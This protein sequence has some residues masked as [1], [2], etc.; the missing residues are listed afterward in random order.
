MGKMAL[1]GTL[2]YHLPIS[3]SVV[4]MFVVFFSHVCSFIRSSFIHKVWNMLRVF[5]ADD[6]LLLLLLWVIW[7]L[8]VWF[9]LTKMKFHG[10][11]F[12][13]MMGFLLSLKTW[14][15]LAVHVSWIWLFVV[16]WIRY[17]LWMEM[18]SMCAREP[19]TQKKSI[20]IISHNKNDEIDRQREKKN[21][22]TW[23]LWNIIN[24]MIILFF[25][26][27]LNGIFFVFF[28]LENFFC[29]LRWHMQNYWFVSLICREKKKHN[30]PTPS[31]LL[32]NSLSIAH[33]VINTFC[34][35]D[36]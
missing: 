21:T 28:R 22:L 25:T 35:H 2:K 14:Q 33:T 4:G 27:K 36:K 15:T 10:I 24:R 8:C 23:I 11:F 34:L 16:I 18:H 32:H 13:N 1:F 19:N 20:D 26:C 3:S 31:P 6:V 5:V 12:W 9:F 17:K 29:S 7:L 30:S